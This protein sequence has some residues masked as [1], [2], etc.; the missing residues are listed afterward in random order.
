M[1]RFCSWVTIFGLVLL[2]ALVKVRPELW[3]KHLHHL[4]LGHLAEVVTIH[5]AERQAQAVCINLVAL[6]MVTDPFQDVVHRP[7]LWLSLSVRLTC[8][9]GVTQIVITVISFLLVI[10][11]TVCSHLF[12]KLN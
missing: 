7:V 9:D 6:H 11:E 5:G 12:S 1:T 3:A 10:I 8:G 2:Q 4:V